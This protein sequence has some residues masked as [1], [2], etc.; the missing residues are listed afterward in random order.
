MALEGDENCLK[1]ES[2][3]LDQREADR[4]PEILG[5]ATEAEAIDHALD[6]ASEMARF[7]MEVEAGLEGL[8]GRGGFAD[9]FCAA[10]R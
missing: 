3:K 1:R 2:L 5:G 9:P 4:I 7:Q 6:A 8:V 10:S